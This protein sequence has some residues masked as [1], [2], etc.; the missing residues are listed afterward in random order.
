VF[1]L[2]CPMRDDK[3][4]LTLERHGRYDG[5]TTPGTTATTFVVEGLTTRLYGKP[6]P[7]APGRAALKAGG[8][9]FAEDN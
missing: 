6:I 1:V 4:A 5:I 8:R 2:T 7:L 3:L 9:Y